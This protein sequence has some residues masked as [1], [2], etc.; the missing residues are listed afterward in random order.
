M[1]LDRTQINYHNEQFR[2]A[3]LSLGFTRADATT[4][5]NVLQYFFNAKCLPASTQVAANG[6]QLH[7][8]CTDATC[9]SRKYSDCTPYPNGGVFPDPGPA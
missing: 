5:F 8:V 7:S 1:S 2:L 6:P 4:L 3:A 9:P